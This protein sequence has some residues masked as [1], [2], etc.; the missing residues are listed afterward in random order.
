M[1]GTSAE[2]A[3]IKG[4]NPIRM[5]EEA[6][7]L[8][9]AE[10]AFGRDEKILV[11][12]NYINS[13]HPSTGNTTDSR[14]IEGTV[15]YLKE[16]GFGNIAIGEGSGF[17]DTMVAYEAAGT[18]EV[19]RRWQIGLLDINK[20]DYTTMDVSDHYALKSVRISKTALNSAIISIP[21][22]KLHRITGVTLSL[23]NLM[24]VVQPKGQMHVHLNEKIAD[25]A[26]VVKPRLA[27]V[28]G[29]IGGEG[30]ET[31]GKP[32]PMNIVIAGLDLVAVDTV[33]AAVMGVN[34]DDVKHIKLASQ[35][36]LGTC[37]LNQIKIVGEPIEKVKRIFKPS[38]ASRFA[39]KFA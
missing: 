36:G 35:K 9:A 13:S 26:S 20:D 16:K 14:V 25:L 27:V 10:Q 37:D 5:V 11:K 39:S 23:K 33:G 15:K 8:I 38:F 1:K 31:A 28:D 17:A 7:T 24:G 22:L 32:V 21:K 34:V 30:H 19:A 3:I 12:P 6:L 18:D 2:V 4:D 29:I